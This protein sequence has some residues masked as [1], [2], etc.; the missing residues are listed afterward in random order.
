MA[1][2]IIGGLLQVEFPAQLI[3]VSDPSAEARASLKDTY[4]VSVSDDNENT[5]NNSK[6]VVL[7]VKPQVMFKAL[8]SIDTCLSDQKPLLISIAAGIQMQQLDDRTGGELP[9]VRVMPN[10]PALIRLG[11]SALCAN[12][13]TTEQQRDCANAILNA[14]G[15]TVW[16][17]DEKLMD[18]VTAVS[19]AGPAYFFLLIEAI[20][21]A[22][23]H[24]GLTSDTAHT[25]AV[26]TAVGAAQLAAQSEYSPATLRK[27]V[28]SPG[29]VTQ[30]ALRVLGEMGVKDAFIR[31]IAAGERRSAELSS[32][33]DT[34]Q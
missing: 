22:A 33:A 29:G 26:R 18:A 10:T 16:F 34:T 23:E 32:V 25:L 7:A 8:D 1:R 4:G 11:V 24:L 6:V 30:E 9:I 2:S 28:T 12:N 20:E 15:E 19:G 14:V 13:R 27:Q 31:A 17:D 3:T 21:Q 5:V